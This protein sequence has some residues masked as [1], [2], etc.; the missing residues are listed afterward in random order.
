MHHLL[1]Y[2]QNTMGS[3]LNTMSSYK[4]LGTNYI[5]ENHFLTT[6]RSAYSRLRAS[7]LWPC[8]GKTGR[9]HYC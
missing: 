9:L 4:L 8:A 2:P 1:I 5:P 3:W 7:A 6:S